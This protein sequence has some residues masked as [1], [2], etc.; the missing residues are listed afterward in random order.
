MENKDWKEE[1]LSKIKDYNYGIFSYINEKNDR[2]LIYDYLEENKIPYKKMKRYDTEKELCRYHKSWL[3]WGEHGDF[4]CCWDCDKKC[5]K[6]YEDWTINNERLC[7]FITVKYFTK[8][9]LVYN[10]QTYDS[11]KKVSR[12]EQYVRTN[13]NTLQTNKTHQISSYVN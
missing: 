9:I 8:H 6:E 12:L 1:V 7:R 11:R 5:P 3:V 13:W 10:Q 2:K 4:G